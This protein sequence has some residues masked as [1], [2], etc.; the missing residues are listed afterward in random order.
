[1]EKK[2]LQDY[3]IGNLDDLDFLNIFNVLE[4]IKKHQKKG[5]LQEY[6][7]S[8]VNS[9]YSP[10]CTYAIDYLNENKEKPGV[11]GESKVSGINVIYFTLNQ[12][13]FDLFFRRE[14]GKIFSE[15][16][17]EI[18][19][20]VNYNEENYRL[21]NINFEKEYNFD[22]LLNI[23]SL[24]EE[25]KDTEANDLEMLKEVYKNKR[26]EIISTFRFGYTV[27]ER[28]MNTL[29]IH[30]EKKIKELP[31]IIF[32]EKNNI[33]K[34]Y[35][36]VDRIVTVEEDSTISN[37]M[38][39]FKSQFK[40]GKENKTESFMDGETLILP[41]NSCNFIEVKTSANFFKKKI[42][43]ENQNNV[44]NFKYKTPSEISP[45]SY[46]D[47]SQKVAKQ[48]IEKMNEF[49]DLFENINIKYSQINLIII[50]DSYYTTD[51]IEVA[52][53]FSIYLEDEEF[54]LDF[55]LFF[56]HIENDIIYTTESNKYKQLEISL[57]D[58][59]EKINGLENSFKLK[60]K[61]M[62][63]LRKDMEAKNK[64]FNKLKD[65]FKQKDL[66]YND[67]KE[68]LNLLKK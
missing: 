36:E 10:I 50:I 12:T 46:K 21:M 56:V 32:F 41:K 15:G 5:S 67:V 7:K 35:S 54:L 18:D 34:S 57:K 61:E 66:E 63:E 58:K 8:Y 37:F 55:N 59:E 19:Y 4:D 17:N 47:N 3:E 38:V 22:Q 26:R 64:D 62:N 68:E 51:F 39:Y 49:I 44:N 60:E 40:K 23:L 28:I 52:K 24:G 13:V 14:K 25:M 29:N 33:K 27:Q 42:E 48:F 31:N 53:N 11:I 30:S 20:D 16:K 43:K 65:K 6:R 2:K 45:F 1:M 9:L